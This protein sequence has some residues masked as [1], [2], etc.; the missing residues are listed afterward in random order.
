MAR[1]PSVR[2]HAS[3]LAAALELFCER[4]I[5]TTS[6]D[7]IA[8]K[9]GVSKATIYK[10]WADKEALCLDV[11]A[12]LHEVDR[13]PEFDSGDI[14]ADLEDVLSYRP[15]ERVSEQQNRMLPHLIA[16]AAR[17]KAFGDAWRAR[18]M[19][20]PIRQLTNLLKRGV[21]QGLLIDLDPIVGVALLLGPMILRRIFP[22]AG[23]G[24]PANLEKLV[25]DAFWRA[26]AVPLISSLINPEKSSKHLK[27]SS[28]NRS[29]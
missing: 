29:A 9:S 11:L 19:E 8:E 6:M 16:Y 24:L 23:K 4:G 26:H 14:R 1:T 7:A 21:K 2:A 22:S 5:D 17:N 10:H 28:S 12:N 15:S 20:P 3:V 27:R 25:V 18:V 13:R